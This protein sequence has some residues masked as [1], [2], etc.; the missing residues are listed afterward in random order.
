M[1][2]SKDT[3]DADQRMFDAILSGRSADEVLKEAVKI[4]KENEARCR[5]FLIQ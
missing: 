1:I 2:K 3:L 5:T 4:E